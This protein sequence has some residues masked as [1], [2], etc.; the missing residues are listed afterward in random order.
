MKQYRYLVAGGISLLIHGVALSFTPAKQSISMAS[1]EQGQAV[2]ITF[3]SRPQPVKTVSETPPTKQPKALTA[4]V[5]QKVTPL[6]QT[7]P[8]V[9]KPAVSPVA[10]VK[11][12]VT[13]KKVT[14]IKKPVAKPV[15]KPEPVTPTAK[16]IETPKLTPHKA[17]QKSQPPTTKPVETKRVET[18][19]MQT[20][21]TKAPLT[22]D[23]P[24]R[25]TSANAASASKPKLV[26]TP[27]FSAKPTAVGYPRLAQRRG[28]QGST[29]I[30]IWINTEGKQIKQSIV[31]SSG[32]KILDDAA[33]KSVSEW[34]F[35]RHNEQG[36]RIAYRV[37]VP[38]NF[39]LQ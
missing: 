3:V 1:S 16:K 8:V 7:K 11:S 30:E 31:S 25:H 27:T 39:K 22:A 15:A 5:V 4:P 33:M 36:Q 2:S 9:T 12:T 32:H 13:P 26:T 28:L 29:L 34:Q 37:Q 6:K 24:Q 17:K 20:T 35:Q 14:P 10:K 21:Q 38:I 19:P 18:K 23:K